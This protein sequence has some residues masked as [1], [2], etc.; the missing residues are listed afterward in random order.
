M[1]IVEI[2]FRGPSAS[3]KIVLAQLL[4]QASALDPAF[5]WI[6]ESFTESRS[7]SPHYDREVPSMILVLKGEP[8][9]K[10]M[11]EQTA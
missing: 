10:P 2:E 7:F 11:P 6:L 5:H 9:T 3:G 4:V 1:P 8:R